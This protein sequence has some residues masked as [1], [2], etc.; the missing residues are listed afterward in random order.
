MDHSKCERAFQRRCWVRDLFLTFLLIWLATAPAG[1]VEDL[2]EPL[3]AVVRLRSTM[4]RAVAEAPQLQVRLTELRARVAGVQSATGAGVPV[5]AWQSEGIGGG[6]EPNP[7]A[8]DKLQVRMPFNRPWLLGTIRELRQASGIWFEAGQRATGLQVAEAAG[9][10]WLDLA[11]A[12]A[13]ARLAEV[14]LARLERALAIQRR[15][16]ELGEI[17]GS[18]RRQ[19]ELQF[20]R[21]AARARQA[22]SRRQALQHQLE[23]LA[24]GGPASPVAGDLELLVEETWTPE[25]LPTAAELERAP[26][27]RLAENEA[28]VALLEAKHQRRRAW[29]QPEIEVEWERVPDLDLIEGFDSFGFSLAFPLPVGKQGRQQIRAFE[30]SAKSAAAARDLLNARLRA[31]FEAAL[32]TAHGAE[33]ALEALGPTLAEVGTTGRSLSEQFRL[34]A[35]SYLV[36]LDGFSRVDQVLQEAIDA[37]H[38]LLLARLELAGITG[39]DS[40][41]P[42]PELKDEDAS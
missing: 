15:R 37:R 8:V 35:I 9:R 16:F 28:E 32:A 20:A 7:T 1:A 30:E 39:T 24:P 12:T 18:E 3:G 14:R 5:V 23:V 26:L 41:F 21:E 17:S 29:G 10:G 22:E 25:S 34:G 33:A 31:R 27:Q 13:E 42:L 19:L 4:E 36:Y 2:A 11:A 6:F 38:A 40:F